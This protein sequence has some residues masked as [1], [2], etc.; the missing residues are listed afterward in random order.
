MPAGLVD[1][2][3]AGV[4]ARRLRF[5]DKAAAGFGRVSS[6]ASV[7]G[8]SVAVAAGPF[9][10]AQG[11][12]YTHTAGAEVAACERSK[13]RAESW[14]IEGGCTWAESAEV[15]V[16]KPLGWPTW[17]RQVTPERSGTI[18]HWRRKPFH[19]LAAIGVQLR[20][21]TACTAGHSWYR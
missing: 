19:R 8:V 10:V 1:A 14:C 7:A 18:G 21:R 2:G 6:G 13:P 17:T 15:E 12:K 16:K 5:P 9:E 11:S 20:R 4:E 3:L